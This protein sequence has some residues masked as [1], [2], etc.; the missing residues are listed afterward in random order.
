MG[1]LK[2]QLNRSTFDTWLRHA[3]LVEVD[4]TTAIHRFI[5]TVPHEYAKDY[6]NKHLLASWTNTLNEMYN[7]PRLD[8]SRD[9]D[10][11]EIILRTED[12]DLEIVA[13]EREARAT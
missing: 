4:K 13:Q 8:G 7:P 2:I 10:G 1:Q 9:F 11:V 3:R 12:E 6:L 5:A